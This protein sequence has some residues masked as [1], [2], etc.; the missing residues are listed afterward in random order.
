MRRKINTSASRGYFTKH[1][2]KTKS[3]NLFTS[4]GVGGYR[5]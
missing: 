4:P 2:T 5:F 3:V 1:A